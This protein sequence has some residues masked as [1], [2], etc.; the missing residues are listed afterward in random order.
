MG[1]AG[2]AFR[3]RCGVRS[4]RTWLWPDRGYWVERVAFRDALLAD[5]GLACAYLD[6]KRELAERH[7]DDLGAYTAAK[8]PFVTAALAG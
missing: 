6:L 4:T 5:P 8:R 7:R 2:C 3:T 1:I